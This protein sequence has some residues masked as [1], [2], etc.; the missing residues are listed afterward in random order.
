[1]LLSSQ[2]DSWRTFLLSRLPITAHNPPTSL[3]QRTSARP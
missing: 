2:A 3:A 1:L